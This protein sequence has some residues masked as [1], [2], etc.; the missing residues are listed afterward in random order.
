VPVRL[1]LHALSEQGV[2]WIGASPTFAVTGPN[3]V[4]MPG[5]AELLT[6]TSEHGCSDNMCTRLTVPTILHDTTRAS[7]Q[8]AAF[9]SWAS[10]GRYFIDL[11]G[12]TMV[13]SF[14]KNFTIG[15]RSLVQTPEAAFA[16]AEGTE[17]VGP[18]E[19][20]YRPDI[21]T[22][23]LVSAYLTGDLP[24][25][26]FV[27]L[28]DT[29]EY[30]HSGD[31]MKY[32]AALEFG[33]QALGAW[34]RAYRAQQKDVTVIVTT[35]HGR[36]HNFRDH[37]AQHPESGFTWAV[38]ADSRYALAR[39]GASGVASQLAG[40]IRRV[41]HIPHTRWAENATAAEGVVAATR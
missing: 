23:K 19:A 4:S 20:T 16:Y 34:L 11:D 25:L 28:G 22:A 41:L 1:P 40:S 15:H 36:A 13:G 2:A 5:Y 39:Q 7:G 33:D 3:Y 37:G 12:T 10:I 21:A 38:A 17:S 35:D 29:D 26:L 27:S 14:G 32:L 31:R 8:A 24:D 30:A 6:G 18:G 9:S